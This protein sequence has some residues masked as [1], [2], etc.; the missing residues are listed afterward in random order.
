MVPDGKYFALVSGNIATIVASDSFNGKQFVFSVGVRGLNIK[1]I[2]TVKNGI[3]QSTVLQDS[4]G[5]PDH[6]DPVPPGSYY[7]EAGGRR[8]TITV[9]PYEGRS[10]EFDIA[11]KGIEIKDILFIGADV[12]SSVLGSGGR[13]TL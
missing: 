9:G 8:S 2:I 7:A 13:P 10:F 12:R 4:L 1:D 5:Y 6:L 11:V 3:A